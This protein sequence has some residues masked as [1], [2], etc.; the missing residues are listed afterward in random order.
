MKIT[1]ILII[2][3]VN[4]FECITKVKDFC[5]SKNLKK[6]GLECHSNFNISCSGLI[7]AT[8]RFSCQSLT[9][10]SKVKDFQKTETGYVF[11]R[12]NYESFVKLI[13]ECPKQPKYKWNSNDVCLNQKDC[14]ELSIQRLWS[15]KNECK[16]NRK[17]KI[18]CDSDYCASDKQACNE[19]KMRKNSSNINKCNQFK[20]FKLIDFKKIRF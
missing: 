5:N 1:L 6:K 8:N 17:Y 11:F 18:K 7:C 4:C 9:L 3:F 19:L 20:Y 16:C 2:Y 10:L 14:I 15:Q 12:N 13:K